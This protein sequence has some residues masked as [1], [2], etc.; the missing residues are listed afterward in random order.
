MKFRAITKKNYKNGQAL[1]TNNVREAGKT[2]LLAGG[3]DYA[4]LRA[5]ET[6]LC[7]IITIM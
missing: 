4:E 5:R 7:D 1:A 3:S 6:F 2:K